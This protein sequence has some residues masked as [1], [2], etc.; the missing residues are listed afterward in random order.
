V[1]GLKIFV[2]SSPPPFQ[3]PASLIQSLI[4]GSAQLIKFSVSKAEVRMLFYFIAWSLP[5][6]IPPFAGNSL[7]HALAQRSFSTPVRDSPTRYLSR[8]LMHLG[9]MPFSRI[10]V[11]R[12]FAVTDI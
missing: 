3:Q 11:R 1:E 8:S 4:S 5:S 6:D 10:S 7:A 12:A 9:G 2:E